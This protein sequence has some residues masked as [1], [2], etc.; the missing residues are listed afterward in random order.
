MSNTTIQ[1]SERNLKRLEKLAAIIALDTC[2]DVPKTNERRLDI[3]L[4]VVEEV[5]DGGKAKRK[6]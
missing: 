2:R 5:V 4:A 1:L 3:I 6:Q